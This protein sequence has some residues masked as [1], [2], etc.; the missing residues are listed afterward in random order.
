MLL[1]RAIELPEGKIT[2][3]QVAKA[4]TQIEPPPPSWDGADPGVQLVMFEKN[5]RLWEYES[6]LEPPKRGVRLL[7]NLTG[8]ARAVADTL[9]FEQVAHEKGVANIM[10]AL[11]THFAPHL[12]VSLPRAFER[13]VYGQPRSGRETMQEYLIRQE[14]NFHL[15]EKEGVKLDPTAVGY[16]VYRQAS[17]TENQE[18]KF[19][20]WSAGKYDLKTVQANLRKL[21]KVVPERAKGSAAFVMGDDP[22][23]DEAE[24][25]DF[26]DESNDQWIYVEESEANQLWDEAEVQVALATYQEIRKAIQTQQKNRQYYKSN[27]RGPAGFKSFTKGKKKISI[28]ELKLR[29]RCGRCGLVGHWAKECKNEP[30]SRGRQFGASSGKTSSSAPSSAS[31]STAQQSWYVSTGSCCHSFFNLVQHFGFQCRG[32]DTVASSETSAVSGQVGSCDHEDPYEPV[33]M[34]GTSFCFVTAS[35]FDSESTLERCDVP[36]TFKCPFYGL[37]TAPC[38]GVVDTA[39][40][41]GLIGSKALERLKEQLANC[42][43]QVKW[44]GKQAKAHGVG[45]QAK[46]LGIIAIPLGIA[47]SSG[48]L[49]ATVVEGEIPLL[50]PIKMLRQLRAVIDLEQSCLSFVGMRKSVPLTVLPSGHIAIEI[51]QFEEGGFRCPV[52]AEHDGYRCDDFRNDS[53]PKNNAPSAMC[54]TPYPTTFSALGHGA[55]CLPSKALPEPFLWGCNNGTQVSESRVQFEAGSQALASGDRQAGNGR[56]FSFARSIG[57][58][59]V[60]GGHGDGLHGLFSRLLRSAR[61]HHQVCEANAASEV[62]D[63]ACVRGRMV[64]SY[65]GEVGGWGKPACSMGDMHRVSF[66]VGSAPDRQEYEPCEEGGEGEAGGGIIDDNIGIDPSRGDCVE[67][68]TPAEGPLAAAEVRGAAA[69]PDTW[70]DDAG[71]DGTQDQGTRSLSGNSGSDEIGVCHLVDGQGQVCGGEGLSRRR[72]V[73]LRGEAAGATGGDSPNGASPVGGIAGDGETGQQHRPET[74]VKIERPCNLVEKVHKLR[75]SGH[76]EIVEVY[77]VVGEQGYLLES[78]ELLEYE[79]ACVLKIQ[80][81]TKGSFEDEVPEIAEVALSRANKK[82]LRAA[83]KDL[84]ESGVFPVAISEV[85][86]P[87]RV[88]EHVKKQGLKVGRCYDLQTGFNLL[89]GSDKQRMWR[90]LHEDDPELVTCSPPCTPFSPIQELNWDRMPFSQSVHMVSEGVENFETAVEV[91]EWQDDRGKVFLLEHPLPSKAWHEQCVQR[92]MQRAGVYVCHTD[93]C[94]YGMR[95]RELPNKKATQW[96]TNSKHMAM[97]LQKRCNGEHVHEPLMG[98][99]AKMAAIYPAQ[100][101][102]AIVRGLLGHLRAHGKMQSCVLPETAVLLGEDEMVDSDAEDEDELERALDQEVEKAG[103]PSTGGRASRE[104]P[105]VEVE[106]GKEEQQKINKLHINLGHPS[107]PSFLRFLKAGRVRPEILRWVR[108]HFSCETCKASSLP[109][110]PRPSL[111]PKSYAP[112]V[113]VGLDLFFIPDLLNQKSIPILN[114]VDLG[115]NYQVIEFLRNKDPKEIWFQFWRSWARTMGQIYF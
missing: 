69:L 58:L 79:D 26:L 57:Q 91:C 98:G 88:S 45:G 104:L 7:R 55:S 90:S 52:E 14:R 96:V 111:V 16:I 87:P 42:G 56:G 6:E 43:L 33:E 105:T 110:A 49:E 39:A 3:E 83:H 32:K 11:K 44:T 21:E 8:V 94:Q 66:Q 112:G 80:P 53:G 73:C 86:S 60:A 81:T 113:A 67:A 41:D 10:D 51:F 23:S 89:D 47:G 40:Q 54:S 115:T 36:E 28:E 68:G 35:H 31:N 5:V 78:D 71:P 84:I 48:I 108:K 50:L 74:W 95:V 70:A 18:L 9:E 102:K 59:M 20:A 19:S 46:V 101:C 2:F 85:F 72:D 13:A 103:E 100:L 82:Q 4:L 106:I 75:S 77:A 38:L 76:Y 107:L 99:L 25:D 65:E 109:K 61:R 93:L 92:L 22:P 30:D 17:L 37:T 114:I 24:E 15:L 12:E 97:E 64:P 29:T 63:K 27:Q 34:R 62:E 1:D